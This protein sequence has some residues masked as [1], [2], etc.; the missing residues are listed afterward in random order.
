MMDYFDLHCD[1]VSECTTKRKS[2]ADNDLHLDLNRGISAFEHWVQTFAFWMPDHLSAEEQY[3]MYQQKLALF[4][5][6]EQA[7]GLVPYTGEAR[8]R[9]CNYLLAVEG[10][11]L[12]GEDISRLHQLKADGIRLLTLT[13]NSEN[14]IG[15][16]SGSTAGLKP[17]GAQIV[18]EAEHLGILVDV[19]HLN[20]KTFWEVCDVAEKPLLATH[21]NADE[22]CPHPR[23]LTKGQIR[24]LV[25]RKGLIGLNLYK[26]F[27]AAD[28]TASMTDFIRHIEYFLDL[29]AGDCLAIG[30]DF[31]G[32][33]M[34]EW[35][36][37]IE[38]IEILSQ[39]V[40]K[41]FGETVARHI[42]YENAVR[43]YQDYLR[44]QL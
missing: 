18:R 37:G 8:P 24:E 30:T 6:T 31:D 28:G 13:W 16:G 27:L 39:S 14:Q 43:F 26:D 23:N 42:F 1:T 20:R 5:E 40:V 15:G 25:R 12:L 4:H 33:D 36:N 21:S 32:A 29:G 7:G 35:I 3:Q 38:S 19:S 17:F 22:I 9:V 44:N 11:G 41:W 34:P 10:G 2:L